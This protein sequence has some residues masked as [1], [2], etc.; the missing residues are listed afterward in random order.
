MLTNKEI[1]E[2]YRMGLVIGLF[3]PKEVVSW[4]DAVIAQEADPEYA[5]I[6]LSMATDA[7][8]GKLATLLLDV[9]GDASPEKSRHVLLGLLGRR[10]TTDPGA[11]A[12]VASQVKAIEQGEGVSLGLGA[13]LASAL[14]KHDGLAGEWLAR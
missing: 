11:A 1:A 3:D 6:E 10:L 9:S 7:N 4:A 2:V 14:A 13:D 8:E 5:I 12:Q